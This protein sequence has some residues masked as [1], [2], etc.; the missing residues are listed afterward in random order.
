MLLLVIVLQEIVTLIYA[1]CYRYYVGVRPMILVADP[2]M[3][4]QITVKEFD[5]FMD[6]PVIKTIKMILN[7]IEKQISMYE[8]YFV[9]CECRVSLKLRSTKHVD[10]FKH[11]GRSGRQLGRPCHQRFLQLR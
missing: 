3:L 1:C 6:R 9:L 8:F 7:E 5:S 10:F 4:K 11:L 2:E